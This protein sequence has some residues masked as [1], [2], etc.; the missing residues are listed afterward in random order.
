MRVL[1]AG[2][3]GVLGR[4]LLRLLSSVGYQVIAL[5]RPGGRTAQLAGTGVSVALADPFDQAQVAK[6]V[7]DA[8]PDV[9]LQYF[10]AIPQNRTRA[11]S[12]AISR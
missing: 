2:A 4:P 9:V 6:A 7:R 5:G 10:T 8:R 12:P 11:A 1:I 3:T